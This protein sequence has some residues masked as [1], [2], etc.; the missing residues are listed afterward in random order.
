MWFALLLSVLVVAYNNLINRWGPFHGAAYV[1]VNLGFA[2]MVTLAATLPLDLSGAELGLQADVEDILWPLGLVA[3][4]TI[5]LFA[6]AWS[7][8]AHRI[9]DRRATSKQGAELI[10]YVLVRIP[11]GTAVTEELVFR[12]ALFAIWRETGASD[13]GA[14][15]AAAAAF[16]LWHI[17]PTVNGL[18]LNDPHASAPKVRIAVLA[19]VLLTTGAGLFLTWLRLE[20]GSL[21]APIVLHAG[22]NSVGALA[23]VIAGRR[24]ACNYRHDAT[25]AE[26][27]NANTM[28]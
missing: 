5:G 2:A 10:W 24:T 3:A 9:A 13:V 21:L 15:L 11:V 18:R 23:A 8:H 26:S 28:Q 14:A 7:R 20:T 27:P 6:I 1:P 19:A 12:G 25:V 4:V 22:V 17:T 16:G